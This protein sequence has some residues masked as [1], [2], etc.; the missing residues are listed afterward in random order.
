MCGGNISHFSLEGSSV[1]FI[2]TFGLFGLCMAAMAIG[3]LFKRKP[4][5]KDCGLDPMT[6][7]RIT[8]CACAAQGKPKCLKKKVLSLFS[9]DE[10]MSMED[11]QEAKKPPQVLKFPTETP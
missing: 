4:L 8:D 10:S 3:L 2:L 11:C 1:E 7:E 9:Q 6:G 5:V